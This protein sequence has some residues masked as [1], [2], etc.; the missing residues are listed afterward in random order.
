[1]L[2]ELPVDLVHVAAQLFQQTFQAVEHRIQRGL[3]SGEVG[4]DKILERRSVAIFGAPELSHLL[5]A[6]LHSSALRFAIL[7]HQ[8]L[9]QLCRGI[10]H[11][12][13]SDFR[14]G[15]SYRGVAVELGMGTSQGMNLRHEDCNRSH[16]QSQD[17]LLIA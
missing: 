13:R 15:R 3:I 6:A 17:K 12:R 2:A 4:A 16:E 8:F 7:R 5:Q 10:F 1:M 9:F 11:P 14:G